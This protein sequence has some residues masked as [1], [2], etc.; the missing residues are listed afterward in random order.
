[1]SFVISQK[2]EPRANPF[3]VRSLLVIASIMLLSVSAFA[4][5]DFNGEWAVDLRSSA[6]PEP[7]LKRLGASWIERQLGGVVQMQATYKQTPDI[8]SVTLRGPGFN[9]TDVMRIN[10]QPETKQDS[11]TGKYTIRTFWAANGTQ[12]NSAIFFRTKDSRDAQLT[13]VRQLADGGKTLTLNGTLKIAGE[14]QTYT[15]R[16]VW[17]R[18]S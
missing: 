12:L 17:R 15:L 3:A 10:N 2:D 5:S 4:A 18:R 9:R 1:M 14:A 6:S 13:I 7:I 8:L 11:R 16:R